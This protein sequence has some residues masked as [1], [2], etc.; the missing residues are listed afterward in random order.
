[1]IA[2]RAVDGCVLLHASRG[3]DGKGCSVIS[4]E[5]IGYRSESVKNLG[6]VMPEISAYTS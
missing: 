2:L 1:M 4:M 6:L 3:R 5:C